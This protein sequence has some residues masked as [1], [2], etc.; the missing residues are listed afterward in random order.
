MREHVYTV[1]GKEL[2]ARY[3]SDRLEIVIDGITTSFANGSI[4]KYI[5]N[6]CNV[7]LEEYPVDGEVIFKQEE[8]LLKIE[9]DKVDTIVETPVV[10]TVPSGV[11]P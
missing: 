9:N 8:D 11:T 4:V 3:Y 6:F 2:R 10:V 7:Y 5:R 1:D